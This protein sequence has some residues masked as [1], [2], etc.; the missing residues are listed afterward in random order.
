MLA[1]RLGGAGGDPAD[2]QATLTWAATVPYRDEGFQ[3]PPHETLAA[4]PPDGIVLTVQQQQYG[5]KGASPVRLPLQLS[6]F[7][8]ASFEGLTTASGSRSLVG[9]YGTST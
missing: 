7:D 6:A 1:H 3:W 4:L 5:S 9:H 2:G 8:D